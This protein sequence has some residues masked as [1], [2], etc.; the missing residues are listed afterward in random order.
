MATEEDVNNSV[1]K[2][3]GEEWKSFLTPQGT[4]NIEKI[5]DFARAE[6]RKSGVP[7]DGYFFERVKNAAKGRVEL[8]KITPIVDS[9]LKGGGKRK[10]TYEELYGAPPEDDAE[11]LLSREDI[12]KSLGLSRLDTEVT[13]QISQLNKD[14]S[15]A[16]TE[17]ITKISTQRYGMPVDAYAEQ[18]GALYQSQAAALQQTYAPLIN[19]EGLFAGTP[20][21]YE[22]YQQETEGLNQAY[23]AQV[24]QVVSQNMLDV[25]ATNNKANTRFNRQRDEILAAYQ[26]QYLEKAKGIN[27]LLQER[28]KKAYKLALEKAMEVDNATKETRAMFSAFG[29]APGAALGASGFVAGAS[30]ITS[31]LF[32]SLGMKEAGEWFE[33]V[34]ENY[35]IGDVE[36]KSWGDMLDPTKVL[37][38]TSYTI[39][40]M[41]PMLLASFG[42]GAATQ[43][44]GAGALMTTLAAGT[45]GWGIESMSIVQEA[46]DQKFKE[47]GSASSAE[48]AANKALNGQL[49]LMPMY[50]LEMVPF[51]GDMGKHL[52]KVGMDKMVPRIVAG[53]VVET[54]AEM[55]QEYP[56]GLFE[57]AIADDKELSA[58]ID[59]ASVAGF[60]NTLMNVAPTTFLLGGA[61]GIRKQQSKEEKIR[62]FAKTLSMQ[63]NIGELTETVIEQKVLQ[64][65]VNAGQDFAKHF[66][67][68]Q[69]SQGKI[70]EEQ[71]TRATAAIERGANTI[72]KAK[73]Y[74]LDNKGS[75][76]LATL[77][78]KL[79][80]AKAKAEAEQDPTMKAIAEETVKTIEGQ[81]QQLVKTGTADVAL[82]QFPNGD[83]DILTHEEARRAMAN[84]L[85]MKAF[86]AGD[87]KFE[88]MG[89]GQESLMAD[90]DVRVK[91]LPAAS[92]ETAPTTEKPEDYEPPLVFTTPTDE[93]YAVMNRGDGKGDVVLTKEEYE[94]EVSDEETPQTNKEIPK[95]ESSAKVDVVK[96][97]LITP[98]G[99][100]NRVFESN[101]QLEDENQIKPHI[102]EE[103]YNYRVLSQKEIDAI[104]ESGGV[105]PRE[106][107]QKGG[108]TNTK[109][110]TKGNNK[111]W[112]GDKAELETIRVR[113]DNFSKNEVVR[114]G[115]VEV[116]NKETKKI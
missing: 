80:A 76:V 59:Y 5:G 81:A 35:D 58:A 84:E 13:A 32:R 97:D 46:Y 113:Q 112:Y 2:G 17:E 88:A 47:T 73:E 104:R 67:S 40:G 75:Y 21:Q 83:F 23:R 85:F 70:T 61:G 72:A 14:I 15:K 49:L 38:S 52:A 66:I 27:P 10:G 36:I 19:Q 74:K 31:S 108:N 39:G 86:Q 20:E 18:L 60:E 25:A 77:D 34:A 37:K 3:I 12:K 109:Y 55:G 64:M 116:Y 30:N 65:T 43:G 33:Q 57:K 79:E 56:Q 22:A 111:N 16:S 94:A 51:F 7:E 41:S 92:A 102:S 6:A 24:A 26:A 114:A 101:M 106:G 9:F 42:V 110:W 1:N 50:A 11:G 105:F 4:V 103:G 44:I 28:Y 63:M 89:K 95:V 48:S 62:D 91:E 29:Q 82:I 53:G 78:L 99:F 87:L 100:T 69:F 45:A 68:V 93:R 8:E 90:L 54:A 71:A 96:E 98:E 115:N 107:K